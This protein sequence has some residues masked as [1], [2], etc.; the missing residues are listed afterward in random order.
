V[1]FTYDPLEVMDTRA[2]AAIASRNNAFE[3][4]S[5]SVNQENF[6]EE[7]LSNFAFAAGAHAVRLGSAAFTVP[8]TISSPYAV[9]YGILNLGSNVTVTGLSDLS[10]SSALRITSFF[11]ISAFTLSDL[12]ASVKVL[13]K[14]VRNGGTKVAGSEWRRIWDPGTGPG[15]TNNENTGGRAPVLIESWL[16]GPVTGL[17]AI[18]LHF[19]A[20]HTGAGTSSFTIDN[21]IHV[22]DE[23][24]RIENL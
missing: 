15:W 5:A 8:T 4:A 6:A 13:M 24:K 2:A 17:T 3:T 18:E 23:F 20:I 16:E 19:Q 9:G 7:G 14:H 11:W 22:V 10:E 12:S 21:G 1:R